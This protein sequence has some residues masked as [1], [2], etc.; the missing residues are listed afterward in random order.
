MAVT[1]S[2]SSPAPA[3]RQAFVESL[4]PVTQAVVERIPQTAVAEI[5]SIM[6]A[7]REAQSR[8]GEFSFPERCAHVRRLGEILFE[9]RED[10]AHIISRETSKPL[11]EAV[12]AEVM[13]ALDLV[14]FYSRRAPRWLAPRRVPHHNIAVKSKTGWLTYEPYGVIAIIA[15]W[16]FPFAIPMAEIIPAL[17]AG[18]AVVF[19]P[20]EL[21]PATGALIGDLF[22]QLAA[23]SQV[24]KNILQVVQGGGEAGAAMVA[25]GPDK[26]CFTGSVATGKR[27]AAACAERLILSVLELGGKDAMLVLA[28]ADVDMAS[29]GAIWGGMSNCGQACVSVERIYVE[30]EI[31][32][33]FIESCVA[34]AGRLR[35]GPPSDSDA[36]IGPMIR[37]RQMEKI[38]AQLE[39]AVAG[40][41]RILY[42]GKPRP[43]LGPSFFEPAVVT[44]VNGSMELMREE[45]FGPVIAIQ[46]VNDAEEAV[47]LANDS[48]FGLAASVWTRD[49]ARGRKI[50]ARLRAG[51]VM[52]NDVGSYY[53]IC[54]APHG[55]RG[56]SGWGRT[57]SEMGLLE[58]VQSKYVNVERMTGM[59]RAWWFGYNQ[60]LAESAARFTELL[61]APKWHR[62]LRALRGKPSALGTVFRGHRL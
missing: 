12:F 24:P 44:N 2:A 41:A 48:P 29:S 23:G 62:R 17:I 47:R 28:D 56:A 13:L 34:K 60:A 57:H 9:R 16:N 1:A 14:Q 53:G 26:V 39:D 30:R 18:N 31:A 59:K 5:P 51:S 52:V 19:K 36:E 43:D 37:P 11:V 10:V 58:M 54:E 20:S 33:K 27:I 22:A 6:G 3:A 46:E 49:A 42:G 32:P 25:G 38:M 45:T 61:F 21:T 15:P 35:L 4:D 40:G 8:W 55:G 50:A 7:A